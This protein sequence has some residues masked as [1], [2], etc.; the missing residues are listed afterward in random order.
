M[1]TK[2]LAWL[3]LLIPTLLIARPH[4]L[5]RHLVYQTNAAPVLSNLI[6]SASSGDVVE[7][8]SG[9]FHIGTQ[10]IQIPV[11]VTLRGQGMT[12]TIISG[13]VDLNTNVIVVLASTNTVE[14]LTIIAENRGCYLQAPMGTDQQT[15]RH[16]TN[17]VMR[18]VKLIGESDALDSVNSGTSD[19]VMEDCELYAKLDVFRVIGAFTHISHRWKL[20][21]TKIV[22]DVAGA[23]EPVTVGNNL[24]EPVVMQ[25][26]VFEFTDCEIIAVNGNFATAVRVFSG[27]TNYASLSGGR[28]DAAATNYARLFEN[29]N[30]LGG[31]TVAPIIVYA[32]SNTLMRVTWKPR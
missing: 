16:Y 4:F 15:I 5:S 14:D 28:I 19:G 27:T 25:G 17:L 8:G 23:T 21:R 7:L 11:G 30:A 12:S 9:T 32:I 1:N 24:A 3:A 10:T 6:A 13:T 29:E 22:C 20:R 26:G 18:R 31:A 2:L